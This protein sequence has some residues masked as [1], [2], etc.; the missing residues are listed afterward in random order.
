MLE[1]VKCVKVCVCVCVSVQ[2]LSV[3]ESDGSGGE[4]STTRYIRVEKVEKMPNIYLLHSR[5][6]LHIM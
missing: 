5:S 3:E 4:I 2:L 1:V 6:Q